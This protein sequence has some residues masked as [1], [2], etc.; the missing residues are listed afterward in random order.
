MEDFFDRAYNND[1]FVHTTSTFVHPTDLRYRE[2]AQDL[3]QLSK[4]IK[5]PLD[6]D[7]TL[8][9]ETQDLDFEHMQVELFDL[10]NPK[11]EKDFN[12][13]LAIK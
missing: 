8:N 6:I 7:L 9:P 3:S 12:I 13:W 2:K 5:T 11:H 4:V 1:N 10:R